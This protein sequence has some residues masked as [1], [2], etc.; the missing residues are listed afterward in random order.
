MWLALFPA[1][2]TLVAAV[3]A[4]ELVRDHRV[5]R[6]AATLSWAVALGLFALASAAVLVGLTVGWSPLVFA[7]YWLAGALLTV[8]FLAVGQLQLLDPARSRW[9]AAGAAAVS[10][11][12]IA[13]VAVAEQSRTVLEAASAAAELPVGEQVLGDA[14][15]RGLARGL[16]IAGTLVIVAGALASA[17]RTRRWRLLLIPAGVLVVAASSMGARA[18][19]T[20]VFSV[21]LAVGVLVM[22]G[23]FAAMR[24]ARRA[25]QAPGEPQ[26]R[27]PRSRRRPGARRARGSQRR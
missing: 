2:A 22:Y 7:I 4:V 17:L 10:V 24:P 6:H 15:A 5:S 3:F 13:A 1:A 9:Y 8:P 27:R 20:A 26:A 18:G 12:S 11:L 21:L 14:L 23:G 25:V 19:D 16:S